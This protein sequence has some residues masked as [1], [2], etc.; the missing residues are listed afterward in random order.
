LADITVVDGNP[1]NDIS[2]TRKV[3]MVIKDGKM[4][5]TTY[6]PAFRNPIPR[7]TR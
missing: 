2:A 1:L 6:D 5:D 4:L 3:G 7:P